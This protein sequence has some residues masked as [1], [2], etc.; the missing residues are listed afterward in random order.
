MHLVKI[1][2]ISSAVLLFV[3][4]SSSAKGALIS[5]YLPNPPGLDST[6]QTAE[7]SGEAG[8]SFS[9]VLLS[10]GGEPGRI[11]RIDSAENVS[12]TFNASGVLVV[13]FRDFLQP[14]STIAL[15]REF[16]GTVSTTDID[17][18]DDGI[19]DNIGSLVGIQD[20]IGVPDSIA[21]ESFLYGSD[22]GGQDF[23]FTGDEP[24]LIFRDRSVGNWYAIND[25]DMGMIYDTSGQAVSDTL[26][27]SGDP[28]STSFGSLNPT[29]VA[30]PEPASM[31]ALLVVALFTV[32]RSRGKRT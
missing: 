19:A 27:F 6:L 20:A 18:D 21:D 1:L 13:N 23:A 26:V 4:Q 17:L 22:L 32:V 8:T 15:V 30:V 5:E 9:G 11:G 25:P 3:V 31:S 10:I 29:V 16:N 28:F 2:Q 14:T 12:G 7:L 24:R